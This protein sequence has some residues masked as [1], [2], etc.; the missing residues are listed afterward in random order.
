M[1]VV[2]MTTD[3]VPIVDR[4][5]SWRDV[6][7]SMIHN[8][9]VTKTS[10]ADFAAAISVRRHN[11]I[12]C[13]SFWSKPHELRCGREQLAHSGSA[14]YLLSWQIEGEALI[15]QGNTSLRQ[16]PGSVTVLDGRR[17]MHI[18]FPCDVRRIVAKMP[19][20]AIEERLPHLLAS[21]LFAFEPQGPFASMLFTYLTELSRESSSLLPS[22]MELLVEN[23]TNLLMI[24]SSQE[25]LGS[26]DSKELRRQALVRYLQQEAC[27]PDISLE[28][29]ACHLN[30]SRRL[31]QQI[32]QEM[33][34]NFTSFITEE[35]LQSTAKKLARAPELSISHVAYG[36]GFNDVSHFN[37][38]FKRR[39]G[40]P[41]SN[42]RKSQS[43]SSP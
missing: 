23:V 29:V 36:S 6:V 4:G 3:A 8:V 26:C 15:E 19:A 42:Y 33:D 18:S 22:D 13:A 5:D 40:M 27:D 24:T 39:F 1:E 34:T 43:Q 10:S 41:P 31:V 16:K 7:C 38:L 25:D 2:T 21:H 35:R 37:H 9:E 11:G 14:G 32:L 20:R 12:S 28:S 17:P 30:M